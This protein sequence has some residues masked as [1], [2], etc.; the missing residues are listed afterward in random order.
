MRDKTIIV[1]LY[2]SLVRPHLEYGVQAWRPHYRKDIDLL[3]GVL[4]RATKLKSSLKDKTHED[5]LSC[6]KLTTLE[7]RRLIEVI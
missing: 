6:L 3:E 7:T 5:I 4:R 2:E 1:Q